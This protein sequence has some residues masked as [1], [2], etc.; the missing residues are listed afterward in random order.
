MASWH[1]AF[2]FPGA[3]Q[4]LSPANAITVLAEN[5]LEFDSAIRPAVLIDEAGHIEYGD[6][7]E[8]IGAVNEALRRRLA[9]G[10]QFLVE[11]RNEDLFFSCCFATQYSNPYVML[12]WSR[13]LFGG[14]SERKRQAYRKMLKDFAKRCMATYVIIVDDPPDLFEDRFLEID[15][16]R[17]LEKTMP[18]GR[19]Y[20]ILALWIDEESSVALPEGVSDATPSAI[21]NGY[22]E[23]SV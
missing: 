3:D 21:G 9:E 19:I 23:Y 7:T 10:E 22:Q 1:Y 5:G 2:L 13:R 4:Q 8:L 20:D 15:G 17:V 16:Q 14:L 11:C 18:S 6:E 12:G